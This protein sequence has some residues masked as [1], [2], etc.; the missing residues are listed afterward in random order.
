[1]SLPAADLSL[2]DI[3]RTLDA[4][5]TEAGEIALRWFRPGEKTTAHTEYK[6]GGSPVTEADF[7]V[8]AFLAQR[9]QALFP[10]AAWLSEETVDS[11]ARLT[12]DTVL[13]VDPIDGTRGFASGD[14]RWSVSIALVRAGRPIAGAIAAPAAGERFHAALGG[15][16]WRNG[17]QLRLGALARLAGGRLAGPQPSAGKVARALEMDLVPRIPS[18]AMRFAMVAQG[19]LE[20]ALSSKDSHDWDIAAADL[21][22]HEAGG[23][24]AGLDG[25]R[26]LYNRRDLKH[27]AL[28]AAPAAA[29]P[30]LLAAFARAQ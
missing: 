16:A 9:L 26:P 2:V 22:L 21:I 25:A 4:V 27:G 13:I 11:D 14:T 12:A 19:A 24:L 3:A 15:G 7:A 29:H 20:G 28:A 10:E 1:M 23:L 5:A 18:L 8:D 6:H 30:E 17:A